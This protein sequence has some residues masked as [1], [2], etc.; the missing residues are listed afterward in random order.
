[1]SASR[2]VTVERFGHGGEGFARVDGKPVALDGA[3]PGERV[4]VE[5]S[6]GHWSLVEVESPSPSRVTP[7]CPVFDRCGGCAW[8]HVSAE[9]QRDARIESVRRAMP[10]AL[11]GLEVAYVAS[12]VGYGY[13][14]RAR[15]HWSSRGGRVS[16]GFFARGR[17]DVVDAP[18]CAVL[19]PALS[20][21]LPA[22]RESLAS[23]ARKGEL[24]LALGRGGA[25]VASV[26]P[27]EALASAGFDVPA[28]LVARGFAGV[29]LWAPGATAPSTAGDPRPVVEGADG[30]P[31]A[32]A[33]D[34]FS[35]GNVA[36]NAALARHAVG[37]LQ[38]AGR[39]VVELYAGAGNFTVLLA[40]E[41]RR[42]WAVESD[43]A[44]VEALRENVARRGIENVTAQS[45]SAEDLGG[46]WAGDHVLLD[47]PRTGAREVCDALVKRPARRVVY[48]SC[49]AQTLG[50]DLGA[51]A[52]EY[53]LESLTAFEM[54]PQTAHVEVV[55][56]LRRTSKKRPAW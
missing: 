16:L 27:A 30:E 55:A 53:E 21:A 50:R 33:I 49:D 36:L 31:L 23:V 2:L 42:V 51:L 10:P 4:R 9:A 17:H 45:R 26:R 19:A 13:R 11:R 8:Q 7:P 32:L 54:F 46:G 14:G 28:A 15:L 3:I 18:G 48:V 44:A 35:Q 29:A 24:S 25:P 52:A 1:M 43:A 5:R 34:G 20:D 12:P 41:A 40:R 6:D 39:G 47:P 37:A 56:A 22:L 38:C